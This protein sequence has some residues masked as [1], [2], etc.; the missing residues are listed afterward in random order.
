MNRAMLIER[1]QQERR[2]EGS[3]GGMEVQ[4]IV[5]LV[6]RVAWVG[7]KWACVDVMVGWK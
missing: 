2:M 6:G 1:H 4:W 7:V 3:N 5:A